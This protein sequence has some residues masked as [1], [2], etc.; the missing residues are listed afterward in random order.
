MSND[1][2][3]NQHYVPQSYLKRFASSRGQ[4]CVFDKSSQ[5]QF[6][7]GVRNVASERYFYDLPPDEVD[8][9]EDL[10]MFEKMFQKIEERFITAVDEIAAFVKLGK[11]MGSEQKLDL[12]Y[13]LHVQQSR[14]RGARN[15]Q[16]EMLEK[17][18]IAGLEVDLKLKQFNLEELDYS[19][20]INETDALRL[21]ARMI[22]AEEEVEQMMQVLLGHFWFIGINE[23]G[24]ELYTSDDPVVVRA[25]KSHPLMSM[26]GIASK[27]VEIAFPLTPKLILILFERS[28]HCDLNNRPYEHIT[29]N[30]EDVIYYN[31]MQVEQSR[32]QIYS[33]QGDYA[34]ARELCQQYPEF[35]DPARPRVQ[36]NEI[37]IDGKKITHSKNITAVLHRARRFHDIG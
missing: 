14:T 5:K 20:K 7:T 32:R 21:Q 33:N 2:T 29:L 12:A 13:F 31:E 6:P 37:N 8:K 26:T 22:F 17:T 36:M 9:Y 23:T 34:L 18:I 24:K 3:A 27:G 11:N 19:I 28:F 4:V 30:E 1:I 35:C 10:Q 16:T 25:H 15:Q